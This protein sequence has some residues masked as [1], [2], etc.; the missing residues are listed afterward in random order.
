MPVMD[1][2]AVYEY[3]KKTDRNLSVLFCSGFSFSVL[4]ENEF[5]EL[6][7]PVLAKPFSANDLLSAIAELPPQ[8]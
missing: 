6:D 8:D 1:G 7:V 5:K 4:K 2:R 3:I